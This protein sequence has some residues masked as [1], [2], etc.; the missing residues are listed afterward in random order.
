MNTEAEIRRCGAFPAG[1]VIRPWDFHCQGPGMIPIEA[2][3]NILCFR[4]M[5]CFLRLQLPLQNF[6]GL[7]I[8]GGGHAC[9]SVMSDSL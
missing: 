7:N 8:Y 4:E 5:Y 1:P 2:L 6:E 9:L 3:S